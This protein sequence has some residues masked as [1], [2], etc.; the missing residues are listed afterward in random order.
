MKS[1]KTKLLL[2]FSVLIISVA[3]LIS[4]FATVTGSEMLSESAQNT[5]DLMAEDGAKLV[6]SRMETVIKELSVISQQNEI[7]SMSLNNQ[8]VILNEA[9]GNSVFMDLAIVQKNGTATYTDGSEK[10]LS[11]RDYITKAL[12]GEANIS[13]VIIS[14]VTGE[15]VIMVAVPIKNGDAVVGALIGRLNGTALSDVTNDTGYGEK[16]YAYM[17]NNSGQVIAHPNSDMVMN[18]VNPIVEAETQPSYQ[19]LSK[20]IQVMLEKRNGFIDY[21]F[22][23]KSI[24][25]GYAEV[26]GTDWII[27]VTANKDEVLSDIPALQGKMILILVIGLVY[28]L[29]IVYLIGN[30]ITKPMIAVTK[31]SKKIADLDVSENVPAKYLRWKDENGIL[32][33]AMQSIM[34]NLRS[35]IGEI[36]DASLQ[37]S[38]T[39]QELTAT[40]EQSAMSAEEVSRTVE[41]I[42]KGASEQASNTETGSNEAIKLGELIEQSRNH[43]HNMNMASNKVTE[44]VNGGLKEIDHLTGISEESASAT[45]EIYDIILKTNESTEQI[46]EAS[47][48]ISAIAEQTNLLALNASIEAARAGEAGKGFAV[49]AD[50]IKKLAGQ[51]AKSTEY[52][53]GIISELKA[54]VDRAVEAMERVNEIS[55]EQFDSVISTKQKYELIMD[56]MEETNTAVTQLNDSEEEMGVSKNQILDMLQTLSAI[57]EEN[58]ASTE[59]ASSAMVEQSA[60]MEE[61]AKSSE[62]L[63]LLASSLQEIIMKFKVSEL[64][65]KDQVTE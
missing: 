9:K 51:S 35:I 29:I 54:V 1:I 59:E 55:K 32:A 16:G 10:D 17:L 45:K 47:N 39:A 49:V 58:A 18:Q 46:G 6:K 26:P 57:A 7:R 14:K 42:A 8:L 41:E 22:E 65:Y 5:V 11:D 20:A 62:R 60:S 61:I 34:D 23:G 40:A 53:D 15:A 24:Y 19:S 63:A 37:V 33:N 64:N 38:S 30:T 44:V 13:D 50:E 25:S 56:A 3:I 43:M 21:Q 48:V 36:T 28:S 4:F 2:S 31:L 52:I 12:A 27:V